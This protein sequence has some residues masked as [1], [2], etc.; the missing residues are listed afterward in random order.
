[1]DIVIREARTPQDL[2]SAR[3]LILTS[4]TEDQGYGYLPEWH[5]DIDHA[6][7]VYADNPRHALFIAECEGVVIG[8]CAVRT[9]GPNVPPHPPELGVRYA[10]RENVC[11]VV[12]AVTA[13]AARRQGVARSLV[14]RC[15]QHAREAGFRV[16]YLHTN[17][18]SPGALGF[19]ER[20]GALLVRDDRAD[21]WDDDPRFATVHFEFPLR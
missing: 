14:Q 1:M 7:E 18:H 9:G 2:D 16:A 11:Q 15:L 19:W 12:R 21:G 3:E 6:L 4:M 5:W 17:A 13:P 20:S 10:D 8:T